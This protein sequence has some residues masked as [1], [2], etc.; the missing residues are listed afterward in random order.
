MTS[1]S[2]WGLVIDSCLGSEDTCRC[3]GEAFGTEQPSP[4][5][6]YESLFVMPKD[7]EVRGMPELLV[8]GLGAIP[9]M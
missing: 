8:S 4:Q 5:H 1:V 7:L 6:G 3:L 2:G 9:R